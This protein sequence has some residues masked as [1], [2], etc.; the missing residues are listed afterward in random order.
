MSPSGEVKVDLSMKTSVTGLYAV[1]DMRI[2]A[3][4]QVVSAAGD[5]AVAALQAISYVD[6]H[7]H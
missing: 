4:K 1:G 2:A 5:G 7:F 3:P 6:E